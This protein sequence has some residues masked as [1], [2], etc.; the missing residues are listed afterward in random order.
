MGV[1]PYDGIDLTIRSNKINFDTYDWNYPNDNFKYL[2]SNTLYSNNQAD[3][4][5]LLAA[6]TTVTDSSVTNPSAGLYETTIS[7]LSLPTAN[8]YLYLIYDYRL[9]SCQEFCYD[10]SSAASACCECAFTYTAY[11]SSTVFTVEANVCNQ[12]LNATYY[13][14]G[15]GT[16][17]AY[18]DFVYYASDGAVG[19]NL[20]VGLYKVSAT[21]Y[22][23]VNQFGLVTAVTT[24]P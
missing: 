2:S 3:I 15:S 19:S 24:C 9:V 14:S 7:S 21:D 5:S 4:A 16:L 8:Q 17:P 10:A 11:P 13:H 18:G 6:A 20:G 22:I 1:F 12:P 23:T